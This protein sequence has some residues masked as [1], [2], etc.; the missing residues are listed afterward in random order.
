M[1]FFKTKPAAETKQQHIDIAVPAFGYKNHVSI[2]RRR[3]FIRGWLATIAV[4]DGA[5]LTEVLARQNTS[6]KVWADT[7]YRSKRT[8]TGWIG[9]ASRRISTARSQRGGR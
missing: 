3:D 2:D 6:S 8:M 9:T 7:A 4:W 5:E 1:K